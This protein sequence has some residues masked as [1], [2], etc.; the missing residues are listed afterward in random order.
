MNRTSSI[1]LCGMLVFG[2]L[3][4]GCTS[5]GST[6]KASSDFVPTEKTVV[7]QT[8]EVDLP[9]DYDEPVCESKAVTGSRL[10]Q[11]V[12]LTQRQ[13]D[14]MARDGKDYANHLTNN[15]ALSDPNNN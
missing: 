5:T 11:T 14:Q 2:A 8:A 6:Q 13:R 10:K 9:D 1:R 4:V 15:T 12:C 7:V 3:L